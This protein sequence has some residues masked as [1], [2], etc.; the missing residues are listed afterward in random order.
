MR[1]LW[2]GCWIA[3]GWRLVTGRTRLWL[4]AWNFQPYW[5]SSRMGEML[6]NEIIISLANMKKPLQKSQT[7]GVLRASGLMDTLYGRRVVYPNSTGTE[8]P[9][10]RTFWISSYISF[11]WLFSDSLHYILFNKPVN[12]RKC[13]W[14]SAGRC[15]QQ[16]ITF[17]ERGP[18]NLWFAV[19]W[20]RNCRWLRDNLWWASEVGS[21]LMG[22]SP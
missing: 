7:Y 20:D 1:W 22:S 2:V 5:P 15:V 14:N 6:E 4:E 13:C 9:A 16:M 8:N 19:K 18:G 17:K 21:R 3:S 12:L 10:L 11:I